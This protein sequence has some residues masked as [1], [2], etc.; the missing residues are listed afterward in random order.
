MFYRLELVIFA[1]F[2]FSFTGWL[3]ESVHE[4]IIS[5]YASGFVS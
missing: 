4:S 5:T 2:C 1:F 3:A